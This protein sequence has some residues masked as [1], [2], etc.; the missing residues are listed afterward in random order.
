M[1]FWS[2]AWKNVKS[3]AKS[4][5]SGVARGVKYVGEKIQEAG[6]WIDQTISSLGKK[7]SP[8]KIDSGFRPNGSSP[9]SGSGSS[10]ANEERKKG[11]REKENEAISQYQDEVAQRAKL[12][13]KAVKDAY[14]KI[15]KEYIS[16]FEEVLDSEII[17]KIKS[18]IKSTSRR[19]NNTLRD[20]VN[21]KVNSSY[22]PW[23][24]LISSHPTPEHLQNYCDRI[25]SEADNNLLDLLQTSIKDTNKF[26][27]KCVV[28]Y[29]DDKAKALKEMKD[30]L[31]K[32]TAD[33]ET[34][35]QELKKIAEELVVAQFIA[36]EISLD[37]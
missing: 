7:S 24:Q 35:A 31:V 6:E 29:N 21:T 5:A 15:Y 8:P 20:E 2:D 34:K 30:S 16:D 17:D 32:L 14:M 25:Y 28:K 9:N 27:S 1:G 19:F 22:K 23:K 13:E 37:F 4:V 36:N 10:S 18:Y 26:I 33:E 12:R 11:E 3:S